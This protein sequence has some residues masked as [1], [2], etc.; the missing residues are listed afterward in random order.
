MDHVTSKDGT[1]IA[2]SRQGSGPAVILITGGL[3]DGAENATL[4]EE[5]A[6]RY[7]TYN[8][9]RRGRADSGDTL[10]YALEREIEDI[11]ALIAEAG[12]SA[13]LYGVSSGGALAFEAA[14]AGVAADKLAVYEVP[15]L[16]GDDLLRRWREYVVALKAA[17]AD[18]NRDAA[19]EL[20]M[21]LAGSSP[22]TIEQARNSLYWPGL[23]VL[24]PTLVYDAACLGS[25]EP[26]ADRL[27][28][29]TRPTL[30]TT[31]GREDFF[32]RPGDVIAAS[33]PGAE[34]LV[35]SG[36]GHVVDAGEMGRVLG[37]FFGE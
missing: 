16:V 2:Y 30:V 33:I 11:E 20:F 5:L 18:G 31:G 27:A 17:V 10:P 23:L 9:A 32:E 37:G 19:L 1:R 21:E 24:A 7:T 25:G 14:A 35:I 22:E 34:R 3:D 29:I 36:Q 12:G 6:S 13:H 8:Y 28:R 15:Y 26:P 4:A